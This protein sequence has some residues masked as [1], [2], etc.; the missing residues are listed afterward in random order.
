MF[1]NGQV[2]EL[3]FITYLCII[4]YNIVK[5]DTLKDIQNNVLLKFLTF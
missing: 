2:V 3:V 4:N 1:N 5:W